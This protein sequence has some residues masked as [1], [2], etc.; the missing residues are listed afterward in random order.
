MIGGPIGGLVTDGVDVDTGVEDG[1]VVGD[2]V[3]VDEGIILIGV[4]VISIS[5]TVN[6]GGGDGCNDGNRLVGVTI[7]DWQAESASANTTK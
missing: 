5:V 2:A 3:T 6:V 7:A 4:K 1:A